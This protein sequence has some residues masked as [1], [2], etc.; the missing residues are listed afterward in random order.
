MSL[1]AGT[2]ASHSRI[3][4]NRIFEIMIPWNSSNQFASEMGQHKVNLQGMYQNFAEIVERRR[5]LEF[6]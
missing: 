4:P 5:S 2:S 3:K 6:F 1:T